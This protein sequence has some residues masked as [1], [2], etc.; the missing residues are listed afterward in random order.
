MIIKAPTDTTA[1]RK[2]WKQAF[3][4]SDAF[5]DS[6]FRFGFSPSRCFTA[7]IAGQLAGAL[8]WFDCHFNDKKIAYLYA[9]ATDK[10]LQNRG[11]CRTLM[12]H[13]HRHLQAL[14][15]KGSILVPAGESLFGFY[16]KLGYTTCC[17]IAQNTCKA[18]D[19]IPLQKISSAEY[20][21]LRKALLPAGSVVQEGAVL[22][23]LYTQASF[24][25]GEH[26]LLCAATEGDRAFIPEL[27]GDASCAPQIVATLG[28]K[29]GIYRT[30]GNGR[31]FAMYYPLTGCTEMPAYFAFALD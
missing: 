30:P 29:E 12:E 1:L 24:Y 7:I 21:R 20:A 10:A 11:V 5:L 18:E 27:L 25:K 14:G 6:F 19:S 2:L 9:I 28:A 26:L 15:Y 13:T 23:F 8:Y 16:E 31:P 3:G 22:D 17:H 4:D